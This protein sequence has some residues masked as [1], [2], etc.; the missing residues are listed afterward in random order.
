MQASNMTSLRYNGKP[1]AAHGVYTWQV[2]AKARAKT[3]ALSARV[4]R[5]WQTKRRTSVT[6]AFNL[7]LDQ[8]VFR[9]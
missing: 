7:H 4:L 3:D 9:D 5:C 1:L 6:R 2:S 8:N